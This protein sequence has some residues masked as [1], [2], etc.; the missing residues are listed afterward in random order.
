[1]TGMRDFFQIVR[2]MDKRTESGSAAVLERFTQGRY[3]MIRK[4]LFA[5]A[6]AAA[7]LSAQQNPS[8][9][10]ILKGGVKRS[11]GAPQQ[12]QQTA[13]PQAQPAPRQSAPPA[14]RQPAP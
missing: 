2:D 3:Q 10:D 14:Q 7:V 13:P 12:Q 6:S 9:S 1:M 4:T 8:L 5:I 11:S